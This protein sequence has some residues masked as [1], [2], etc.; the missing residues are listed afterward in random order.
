MAYKAQFR[1]DISRWVQNAGDRLELVHRHVCLEMLRR[2]IQRSPVGNPD[3]WKNPPPPGYVG[4]RFKNNWQVAIG[5]PADGTIPDADPSGSRA[6]A[7]GEGVLSM[8]TAKDHV[9][10]VNNLPYAVRLEFGWSTQAPAGMVRITLEEFGDV[11]DNSVELAKRD[12][13]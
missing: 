1:A 6:L 9:W 5:G 12:R 4:G 10:V 8:L 13:P 7:E 11:V 3:L 2:V